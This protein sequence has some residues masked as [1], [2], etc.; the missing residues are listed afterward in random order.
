MNNSFDKIYNPSK[1]YILILLGTLLY[2]FS[3]N[4]FILSNQIVTGG[5]SGVCALIFFATKGFIPVSLSYFTINIVLLLI[6]LKVLGFKFL[7]KTI[8]GVFSLSGSLWLFEQLLH[9]QPILHNQPFMSI[10]IGAFLC[11]IGL[12]LVFTA[13]GSTG[14][15]DILAAI[16]NKYKN[17]SM[18]TALL[19][20][21]FVIISSSYMLFQNVDKIVFGFVEMVVGNYTVDMILNSNRRSVQFLIFSQKYDEIA[22][23][24][25]NDLGRGCTIIDGTGGYSQKPVKVI[26]LLVKKSES[27]AIFRMVKQIDHQAFISQSL[28]QGV[29]GEGFDK[30]KT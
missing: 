1:D 10:V 20:F 30:I 4:G 28:V 5:L 6:A 15:T 16:V 9:G 26:I 29:Y 27:I 22:Q 18:G 14:G 2:G 7:I 3:F 23:H 13:G 25:I 21:D 12:G 17:V 11:G 19:M 8:F 24:I